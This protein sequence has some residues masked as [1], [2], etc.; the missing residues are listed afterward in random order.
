M[1]N[2]A[3]YAISVKINPNGTTEVLRAGITSDV[4]DAI[5]ATL[6]QEKDA[7]TVWISTDQIFNLNT[8]A[9]R[10][11]A[12]LAEDHTKLG[13][14]ATSGEREIAFDD[15]SKVVIE[16]S[17]DINPLRKNPSVIP[18][19]PYCYAGSR[20][21]EPGEPTET[22]D[23]RPIF[24]TQ[25]CPYASSRTFNGVEITW[26]NF[27]NKGGLDGTLNGR[28]EKQAEEEYQKLVA[29]FGSEEKLDE[30][31]PLFLLF[32]ACKECGINDG[33]DE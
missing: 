24:Y 16:P 30:A 4:R 21:A 23:G 28:T 6:F 8:Q 19:G 7:N 26:C 25:R 17:N 15:K 14:I 18:A 13:K 22:P 31:T 12:T 10:Y 11:L 32:D 3:I 29:H 5:A 27:L 9:A 33:D 2:T 20:P 1:P